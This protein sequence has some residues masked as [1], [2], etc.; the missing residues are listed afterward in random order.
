MDLDTVLH[1]PQ[2]RPAGETWTRQWCGPASLARCPQLT[3]G[4]YQSFPLFV[5]VLFTLAVT[6]RSEELYIGAQLAKQP[7]IVNLQF[8]FHSLWVEGPIWWPSF[9]VLMVSTDFPLIANSAISDG[10][11]KNH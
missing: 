7:R 2:A 5:L 3:A 9:V 8:H 4:P 10:Y 6:K 11:S 1:C